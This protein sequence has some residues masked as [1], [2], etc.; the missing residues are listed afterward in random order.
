MEENYLE[1]EEDSLQSRLDTTSCGKYSGGRG[2]WSHTWLPVDQACSYLLAYLDIIIPPIYHLA[3]FSSVP[4]ASAERTLSNLDFWKYYC[5]GIFIGEKA[6]EG[7]TSAVFQSKSSWPFRVSNCITWRGVS[8]YCVT[9][10]SSS[11]PGKSLYTVSSKNR[12]WP[13]LK[14]T[15]SN[16]FADK[17]HSTPTLGHCEWYVCGDLFRFAREYFW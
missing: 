14:K 16:S 10:T 12:F 11:C 6:E 17:S 2:Q 3:P 9:L 1:M 5:M 15:L 7:S 4:E 13:F 8:A